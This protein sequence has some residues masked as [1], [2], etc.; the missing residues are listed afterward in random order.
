MYVYTCLYINI[1]LN[2]IFMSLNMML[3]AGPLTVDIYMYA[4]MYVF[5]YTY[6]DIYLNILYIYILKHDVYCKTIHYRY[7]FI[8]LNI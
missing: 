7:V 4:C 1:Y 2:T 5:L 8:C 6:T 3:I